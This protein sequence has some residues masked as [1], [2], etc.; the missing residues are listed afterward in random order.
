MRIN[1]DIYED[2]GTA[3]WD[4][5]GD[6]NL[7][8]LR[9][10][11][12]PVKFNYIQNVIGPKRK[13]GSVLDVGCGGGY[14]AEELAKIGLNVTGIDPSAKTIATARAH[15]RQEGLSIQYIEGRGEELP[16]EADR[17]DIVCCCDVLEHVENY[18]DVISAIARVLKPGGLFFY[19]TI[20]R[21]MVSR[22]I[23]IKIL[24]EWR[25]TSF[26]DANVHVW[27]MFIKPGELEKV[28]HRHR[29][30]SHEVKG[31]SPGWNF[32]AHYLNLRKRVRGDISWQELAERLGLNISVNKSCTYIGYAVKARI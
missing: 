29:L 19:D 15:A 25:R 4:E 14:L 23:M 31:L 12:N 32:V 3:W 18:E 27:E 20:N 13:E 9:F 30:V 7:V 26:L 2:L 16:F 17:F 10:L 1:N 5:N 22:L 6:G 11:N 8:S 28:L 21:T 24:Q